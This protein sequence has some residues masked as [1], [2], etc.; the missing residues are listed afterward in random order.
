[1]AK[2]DYGGGCPCGL[3]YECDCGEDTR[4]KC[5]CGPGGHCTCDNRNKGKNTMN[6]FGF[7]FVNDDIINEKAAAERAKAE[8]IKHLIMPFLL[9]LKKNPEKDVIQWPGEKRIK[10]ID[11]FITKMNKILEG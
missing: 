3:Q 11:D 2:Y 6:D 4:T 1:M 7:S 10:T 5:T 9:N 8:R